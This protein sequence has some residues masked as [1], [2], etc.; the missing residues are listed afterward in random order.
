[1]GLRALITE[2]NPD[3]QWI[4]TEAFIHVSFEVTVA[5]DGYEA[6]EYLRN[7]LPDVLILDL[8]MPR[9]TGQDVIDHLRQSGQLDRVHII[10][11]TGNAL[12]ARFLDPGLADLVLIKPVDPVMLVD[13][14][15]RLVKS[16][17]PRKTP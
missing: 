10:V 14:A 2:D 17:K 7:T 12:A 5:K 15:R 4:F 9:C 16:C 6:I 3:L 13:L 11:V 1:M 8:N